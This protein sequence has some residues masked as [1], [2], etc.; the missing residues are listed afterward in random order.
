MHICTQAS[1]KQATPSLPSGA[2]ERQS[3]PAAR[4]LPAARVAGCGCRHSRMPAPG[5]RSGRMWQG[6]C[7]SCGCHRGRRRRGHSR[8]GHRRS[9]YHRGLWQRL[10]L[11]HQHL[12]GSGKGRRTK[13]EQ[14]IRAHG[15]QT[16]GCPR[17]HCHS[18]THIDGVAAAGAE[19]QRV[20]RVQRHPPQL[21]SHRVSHRGRQGRRRPRGCRWGFQQGRQQLLGAGDPLGA[22][23]GRFAGAATR[24]AAGQQEVVQAEEACG[25]SLQVSGACGQ[26]RFPSSAAVGLR[27]NVGMQACARVGAP[28]EHVSS[29]KPAAR[30]PVLASTP[31]AH[32]T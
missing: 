20:Q 1:A 9:R 18:S 7:R 8:G 17:L 5:R 6:S 26:Q 12:Q 28:P 11:A 2:L 3:A 19:G 13:G 24:A 16:C 31:P 23:H 27:H 30:L 4:A 22:Q 25:P 15:I 21:G 29:G 14:R 10:A 32:L